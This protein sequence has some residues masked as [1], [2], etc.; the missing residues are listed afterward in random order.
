V[1]TH[2]GFSDWLE[3]VLARVDLSIHDGGQASEAFKAVTFGDAAE[4][5]R[6]RVR[7]NLEECCGLDTLGMLD[8]IRALAALTATRASGRTRISTPRRCS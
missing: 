7:R 8:I 2:P 5:E 1:D 3:N 6:E 4:R